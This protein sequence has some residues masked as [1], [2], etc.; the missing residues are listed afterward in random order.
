LIITGTGDNG[1]YQLLNSSL[2]DTTKT[3][4]VS[5]WV[6]TESGTG[7]VRINYFHGSSSVGAD[8][9]ITT[10]PRRISRTFKVLS[11]NASS[12]VTISSAGASVTLVWWGYQVEEGH[13][14]SSYI[15]TVASA[16]SRNEDGLKM[17]GT[18][19][20]NWF[21]QDEGTIL[22]SFDYRN[23][24]N[25][26]TSIYPRVAT[27]APAASA[28]SN[29]VISLGY[30]V[31]DS[32]YFVNARQSG[33]N[34]IADLYTANSYFQNASMALGASYSNTTGKTIICAN[35]DAPSTS[36]SEFTYGSSGIGQVNFTASLSSGIM[37]LKFF[38]FWRD[39]KPAPELQQLVNNAGSGYSP[40]IGT[41]YVTGDMGSLL[42]YSTFTEG[43]TY[44]SIEGASQE[45]DWFTASPV[46]AQQAFNFGLRVI[47]TVGDPANMD[48]NFGVNI[49][50]SYLDNSLEM[51]SV[52][53]GDEIV[54]GMYSGVF[55]G[56]AGRIEMYKWEDGITIVSVE[57]KT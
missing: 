34:T 14:P 1:V 47:V 25:P 30:S 36:T 43:A 10:T 44:A 38:K 15:P 27:F 35:G 48:D 2:L 32:K 6:W 28:F 20:S 50:D 52:N 40:A 8:E 39:A 31:A 33:G 21:K 37:H 18:S 46:E 24:N 26:T 41:V 45:N 22:M 4:T 5:V 9:T 19:F 51:K 55:P 57:F 54:I 11:T 49:N 23:Q 13:V 53:S 7:A 16:L 17:T 3:L 29:P 56:L 12:N 42:N